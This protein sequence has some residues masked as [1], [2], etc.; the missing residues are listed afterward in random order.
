MSD[1]EKK[2]LT[3]YTMLANA[4]RD[5]ED[6]EEAV[7]KLTLCKGCD[8]GDDIAA[9]LSAMML[10]VDRLCPGTTKDM[11][12][13]EFTHFLNRIAIQHCFDVPD[14]DSKEDTP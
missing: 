7:E 11:D 4:Y 8:F 10:L 13:I 2:V 12:L 6:M 1:Y 14:G 3:F 5:P 9:M